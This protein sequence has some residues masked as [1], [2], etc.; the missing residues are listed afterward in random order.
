MSVS[1]GVTWRHICITIIATLISSLLGIYAVIAAPSGPSPGV[2]GL[3][4][5]AAI[6]V[7]LSLWLGIWGCLAGYFSQLIVGFI[8]TPFGPWNLLWALADFFEGLVVLLAFRY[9]KTDVDI[10]A[11]LKRPNSLKIILAGLL[12]NLVIAAIATIFNLL[13]ILIITLIV[14][15]GLS[16]VMYI[17][18]YSRSWAIYVIFGIFVASIGSAI[19]GV[20]IPILGGIA[21]IEGFW[22]SVFGWFAG[23]LIILAS[24]STILMVFF[25]RYL[26]KSSIFVKNWFS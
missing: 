20:G 4:L 22:S 5:S 12:V 17:L 8:V 3:Y 7:P 11:E 1:T 26:K 13:L 18:N 25:T 23:D 10:G 15:I 9:F 14:A 19:I 6:Y 21:P 24:I 16:V 2:S